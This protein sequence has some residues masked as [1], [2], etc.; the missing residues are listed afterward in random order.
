MS[1]LGPVDT[2][3]AVSPLRPAGL[4]EVH[5]EIG[6]NSLA[7]ARQVAST[8]EE[9]DVVAAQHQVAQRDPETAGDVVVAQAR[10]AERGRDAMVRR[11]A[12]V[13]GRRHR[14]ESFDRASDLGGGQPVVVTSPLPLHHQKMATDQPGQVTAHGGRGHPGDVGQLLCG[15]RAAGEQRGQHAR[16]GGL[17]A[18]H[19]HSG[20]DVGATH[21]LHPRAR[22]RRSARGNGSSRIE[23]LGVDT[24]A[25]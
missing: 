13:R 16:P 14:H 22:E 4:L 2:G 11:P 9:H 20:E 12:L 5:A 7:G 1:S 6:E 21:G 19:G 15:E 8:V 24:R 17:A 23:A 3:A 25:S 18:Q 10:V